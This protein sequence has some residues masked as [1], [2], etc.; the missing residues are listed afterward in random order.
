MSSPRAPR[1]RAS[2]GRQRPDLR[3][4]RGPTEGAGRTQAES[5]EWTPAALDVLEDRR[6]P[7]RPRR[8]RGCRRRARARLRGSGRRGRAR[9]ARAPRASARRASRG[10]RARRAAGRGRDSRGAPRRSRASSRRVDV[11]PRRCAQ[12]ELGEQRTEAAAVLGSVDRGER[13]AEQR[14]AGLGEAGREPERRLAPERHD[15]AER[16]FELARRRARAPAS[17]ARDR[18]GR[19]CRSRS[20]PSPGSS[21]R[22][23]P[24]G[25]AGGTP[26]PR[27]R[28]SSR[29]RSPG[30]SGSCPSRAG[31]SP[32]RGLLAVAG[33]VREV[34][35]RRPRLELA[36][37]GVDREPAR[38][39]AARCAPPP[40]RCRGPRRFARPGARSASPRS[41]SP[42][43]GE[44]AL[45]PVRIDSSSRRLEVGMEAGRSPAAR[46]PP[47]RL[48]SAFSSASGNVRPRPSAS[49]T[50]RI[51]VPS[52]V[53]VAG[54]LLEVE[55]RRLHG[56]VV[57]RRLERGARLAR[58][59]VRQLVERVA[60]SE[61]RGELRDREAGRLRGER[62]GARHARVHLDQRELAGLRL[63]GELDVRAAGRDADG[64]RT[65]EG[66]VPQALVARRREASAAARPSTS[67]RCGRRRDRGSRSSRRRCSCPRRRRRPPARTP[68]SP[69][70][71]ARR[72][73]VRSGSPPGPFATRS[74]SS[75]GVRA[76]PPPRPPSVNAGR[77]TAGTGHP[78][79]CLER[80]RRRRSAARA[81]LRLPSRPGRA[82]RSSAR[83]NRV[84][85]GADQLDAV[86]GEHAVL[87]SSTARLSAVWPPSV[88]RSASG[89][90]RATISASVSSVER[91]EVG[92]VGPL[93]VGHDRRRVRV[94]RARRGSPRA[95]S[96]RHA[97]T[98]A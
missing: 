90:S 7:S 40:P 55:A 64:A 66:G 53:V 58:D 28:S 13:V 85:V 98:P 26:A 17:P 46:R 63:V 48:S 74:R 49:P 38:Q 19:R 81:G 79:S 36:C 9:R 12:A 50:A 67:R 97:C 62:R 15:D 69:R 94:R 47:R 84:D 27:A 1:P 42:S 31:R 88:G 21:S 61:Q 52:R 78:S 29:T 65:R 25:R 32:R 57:E 71:T 54:E 86:L 73:P 70:A 14:H 44:I 68:A 35:V 75:S 11:S 43:V 23:R 96:T 37:A 30:R 41:T 92:R 8:R 89:R 82:S 91:L 60:D 80:G 59:V 77:T 6:R 83:A 76:M 51:S 4:E 33:L 56:D 16:P 10:R 18:A 24:R 34:V 5:P 20:T 95:R 87:G 45:A 93:G 39:A 22:A 3:L 2:V 72:A